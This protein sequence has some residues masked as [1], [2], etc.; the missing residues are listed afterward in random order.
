MASFETEG[1]VL[2]QFDLGESDRLITLYTKE[3][4]KIR[5]VARGARKGI[6]SRSGLVLPFSYHNFTL[7]KGKSMARINHI[8]SKEMNSRLREDLDYMAYASVVSEYIERVGLEDEKDLALFSLL[9][10]ILKEMNDSD[11]ENLLFYY[12]FFKTKLLILLGIKPE[13]KKCTYCNEQIDYDKIYFNIEYG[14]VICRNCKE[15]YKTDYIKFSRE[16]FVIFAKFINSTFADIADKD[17][18][19]DNRILKKVSLLTEDFIAYHLDLKPKSLS[20][21]YNLQSMNRYF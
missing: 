10:L 21:L 2:K 4:G 17:I 16:E 13:L 14:G 6:K 5:A 7:Y 3:R 9:V 8:E 18:E 20:F 12:I 15:K 19:I 1:V 11:K